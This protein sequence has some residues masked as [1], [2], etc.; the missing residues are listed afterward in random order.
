[1]LTLNLVTWFNILLY[2]TYAMKPWISKSNFS[3]MENGDD[4]RICFKDCLGVNIAK[5]LTYSKSLINY[6]NYH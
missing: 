5:Y 6:D 4:N 3:N 1:M 2:H